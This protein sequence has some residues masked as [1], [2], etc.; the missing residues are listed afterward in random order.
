MGFGLYVASSGFD[1]DFCLLF[2]FLPVTK[3]RLS[4]LFLVVSSWVCPYCMFLCGVW[5]CILRT[6]K[7]KEPEWAVTMYFDCT[8][9]PLPAGTSAKVPLSF[10]HVAS[11]GQIKVGAVRQSISVTD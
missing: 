1:F 3:T 10:P 7:L 4:F 5:A 2:S 8:L 6:P 9:S 11:G